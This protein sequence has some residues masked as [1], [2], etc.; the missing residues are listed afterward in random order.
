MVAI[1]GN[2]GVTALTSLVPELELSGGYVDNEAVWMFGLV[3]WQCMVKPDN[4][5]QIGFLENEK[6]GLRCSRIDGT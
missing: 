4:A 1:A 6:A 2:E 5:F 3:A